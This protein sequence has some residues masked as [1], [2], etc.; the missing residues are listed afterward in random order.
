MGKISTLWRFLVNKVTYCLNS[1]LIKCILFPSFLPSFFPYVKKDSCI[2]IASM[3]KKSNHIDWAG[4]GITLPTCTSIRTHY[5]V[6]AGDTKRGP[7]HKNI[8]L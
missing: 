6:Y 3:Q 8:A 4:M 2:L 1:L 7:A 5:C